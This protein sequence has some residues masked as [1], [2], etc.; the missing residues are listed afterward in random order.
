MKKISISIFSILVLFHAQAQQANTELNN[1]IQQSFS[2]FPKIKELQQAATISEQKVSLAEKGKLPLVSGTASYNYVAPVAEAQFPLGNTL[3]DIQ[4]QPHNNVNA[5]I[6]IVHSIYDFGK[7]RLNIERAKLDLLQSKNNIENTKAQLASQVA[8]IY[9]T[10][11]YL[12]KAI[13]VQD[14]VISVLEANKKLMENKFKNGDAL[15]IDVLTLQNNIDIEQNRKVDLQNNLEK[16][17]NLLT[18]ATGQET[19]A[20]KTTQFDFTANASAVNDALKSAQ[21]NNYDF[22]IAQQRIKQ[23]ETELALVR[24]ESKPSI[25]LNGSTGF[26]NGYQP[27]IQDVR[28]N[29]AVGAG[30]SIPIFSGGRLKQQNK[31]ASSVVK[32][33]ELVV[34]TLNNQYEKDI[35]QAITDIKSNQER[36]KNSHE[37]I[38]IA[39]EALRLAQSRYNNGL[40]TNVELL[41]ANTNV[42]KVELA[43]IQYQYQLTLAN[44]ELARLTGTVYWE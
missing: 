7:T 25:N 19:R 26:R 41:N 14:S 30:V 42:Q 16:Q 11:I 21:I 37:Q 17:F 22:I 24:L 38:T 33:N 29:Y 18:Y 27:V 40:S 5:G 2:Y 36:L 3:K 35:K 20:L 9:Y 4:F 43:A 6:N 39:K 34:E 1:I 23:A 31:I 15:K 13:D 32:Q 10:I 12:Q 8:G 44:I 28:F